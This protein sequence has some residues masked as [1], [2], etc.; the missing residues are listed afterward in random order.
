MW[1][2]WVFVKSE[3]LILKWPINESFSHPQTH[4]W[5][6]S[7]TEGAFVSLCLHVVMFAFWGINT[8]SDFLMLWL[9]FWELVGCKGPCQSSF[10]PA[11]SFFFKH[12]LYLMTGLPLGTLCPIGVQSKLWKHYVENRGRNNEVSPG[13]SL[14]HSDS[15]YERVNLRCQATT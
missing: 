12:D 7:G 8:K 3:H 11:D 14:T 13:N 1:A 5:R 10:C 6:Q 2:H 15:F 9:V 4:M